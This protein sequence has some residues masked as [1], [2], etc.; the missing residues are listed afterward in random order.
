[1]SLDNRINWQA[2]MTATI[3]PPAESFRHSEPRIERP[4]RL[5][6]LPLLRLPRCECPDFCHI[7]HEND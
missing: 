1:M 7:D 6:R 5:E 4:P 2:L 3:I